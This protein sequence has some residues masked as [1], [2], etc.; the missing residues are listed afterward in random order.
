MIKCHSFQKS[1]GTCLPQEYQDAI[2][3][4]YKLFYPD[5]QGPA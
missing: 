3:I 5:H 1:F 2:K 4:K